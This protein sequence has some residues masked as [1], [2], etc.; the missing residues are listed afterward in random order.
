MYKIFR[1]KAKEWTKELPKAPTSEVLDP[2]LIDP[3]GR[4][5]LKRLKIRPWT[6]GDKK[7][8]VIIKIV[9]IIIIIII[10]HEHYN[11]KLFFEDAQDMS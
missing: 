5:R 4:T 1:L 7:T 11:S 8:P 6:P 3:L 10:N 9:I 2:L